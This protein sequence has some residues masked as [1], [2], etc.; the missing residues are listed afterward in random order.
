MIRFIRE[1]RRREVF[2]TVGLY[3]GVCWLLIEAASILLPAFE[4]PTWMLRALV[5]I[6]VAGFPIVAVLAWIY[7]ITERRV[8]HEAEQADATVPALGSRKMDFVVIGVLAVALA[9]SVYLNITGRP[10][11]IE[12]PEPVSL[13]ITDF[14]NTTG[15]IIFDGLLEQALN[16]GIESAPHVMS[17][18]RNVA[19]LIAAELQP[20]AQG[21]PAEAARLVAVRE[22]VD[23]VLSGSVARTDGGRF[24]LEVSALD[25]V[26]GEVGFR[27][28]EQAAGTEAILAAVGTLAENVRDALGDPTLVRAE[29]ATTETFTAAS[30]AAASAYIRGIELSFNGENEN[31]IEH[32]RAATELDPR[33]GRAFA[34]WALSEYRLGREAAAAAQWEK[35]LSLLDT[36]T[37]RERL[38]TLGVYYARGGGNWEQAMETFAELVEKYPADASARNNLAVAA[39][40]L[41]DFETAFAEGG[42]VLEMF[43]SSELYRVNY[44]LYAMYAGDFDVAQTAAG[45]LS[46]SNPQYGTAY[47]PL[48]IARL[49]NGDLQG[50]RDAYARMS[51]ATITQH[52]ESAATLGL[53]DVS[54]YLGE[55]GPARD[56]LRAGI[57]RDLSEGV[58]PAAAT[59][60][61][62]LAES[63][64]IEGDDAAAIA[65]AQEALGLS[66][67]ESIRVAAAIVLV[68]SGESAAAR[69]IAAALAAQLSTSS[70]AYGLMIEA[71]IQRQSGEYLAA[72]QTLRSALGVLDLWRIRYELGRTYLE[73]GFLAEAFDE[74]DTCVQRR[75]EAVALFL[76]DVPTYRYLADLHYWLA[77][78]QDGLGMAEAAAE[79]YAAFLALR[80]AG[81]PLAQDA[82]SRSGS[83]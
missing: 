27:V 12:T 41:L 15:E 66:S 76:D 56:L 54:L 3:V 19:E 67:R 60:H 22:G 38:R 71:A 25:P 63:F 29:A 11:V 53:A 81:G 44:A 64:V 16:I 68:Q 37:E 58:D 1:L 70:R 46:D 45:A 50:A 4:A 72:I 20:G 78:A 61:V 34:A 73:A 52:R 40:G 49:A 32:L 26:S 13:L 35:A 18:Q 8:V 65:A 43:P 36:M 39:F 14:E 48:A 23:L 5:L 6:A 55:L 57:E 33:F 2:R 47:I 82:R 59:K 74:L 62:A 30:L 31:A 24:D 17:Y 83:R 69:D 79:S 28:T 77:R 80:P 21:L 51:R 42:R 10:E 9:F 7:D 75:G